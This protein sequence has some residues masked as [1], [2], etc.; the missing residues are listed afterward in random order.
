MREDSAIPKNHGRIPTKASRS[1]SCL[2]L[3][4]C[5]LLWEHLPS[6]CTFLK[7]SLPVA[8]GHTANSLN[9]LSVWA[10]RYCSVALHSCGQLAG[11]QRRAS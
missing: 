1:R 4:G 3:H 8:G 6:L 11:Q 5:L 7:L 9:C 2:G 10:V